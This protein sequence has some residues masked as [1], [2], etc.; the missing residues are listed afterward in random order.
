MSAGSDPEKALVSSFRETHRV[1]VESNWLYAPRRCSADCCFGCFHLILFLE[2]HPRGRNRS[3][4]RSYGCVRAATGTHSILCECWGYSSSLVQKREGMG[5][6]K[7]V[8][9]GVFQ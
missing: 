6:E 2:A 4:G 5:R 8:E 1:S 9:P 7:Q 3:D